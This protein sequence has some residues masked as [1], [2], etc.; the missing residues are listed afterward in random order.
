MSS[1]IKSQR[2]KRRKLNA[3]LSLI[4]N[5]CSNKICNEVIEKSP[6]LIDDLTDEI[7]S[8]PTYIQQSIANQNNPVL[9]DTS[10]EHSSC[11]ST[12]F[13]ENIRQSSFSVSSNDL[14][15]NIGNFLSISNE[16]VT[17]EN[18]TSKGASFINSW[19]LKCNVP[20]ITLNKLLKLMK[21]HEIINTKNLPLD[22]RTLLNTPKSR[23]NRIR[24]VEPGH[25]Y[26][27]GLAQQIQRF[28]PH[29]MT[30]IKVVI[31][32]DGL[33]IAMSCNNQLW[34]ILAY[35]VSSEITKTVFPVGIYYGKSKPNDS[36][37][38]LEDFIAEAK[39]LLTN[40]IDLHGHNKKVLI[41][42]FVCDAPARSYILK[43][44]GHSGYFSCTRCLYEG[45]NCESRVCFPYCKN[46]SAERT[47][48]MYVN[49]TNE[50][51]H[52][53][54]TTSKL[55]ELPGIDLIRSFPLDYMH[56]VN[57]GIVKK[58]IQLWLFKGPLNVRLPARSINLLSTALL[59]I[60]SCIPS[61]FVRKTRLVQ[62]VSRW[63]A[64]EL[65]LFILYIG[66]IVL[67]DIIS[68]DAYTNFMALH[69]AMLILL[70]PN[71]ENFL[72]YARELLEYFVKTF[73]QIYGSKHC[74]YNVHALLHICDDYEYYGPL[75][76]CS[77]FVFEN[78][79]KNLKAKIRKHEKPLEQIINRY[80]EMYDKQQP[81]SIQC[82]IPNYKLSL[83]HKC[84]PLLK[85]I[86]FKKFATNN[87]KLNVSNNSDCYILTKS[88]DVFKCF[89]FVNTYDDN[90]V[91]IGRI[92]EEK[93]TFYKKPVDTSVF[94][95]N[96]VKNLSRNFCFLDSSEI[97]CKIM[98]LNNCNSS[99]ALPVIHTKQKTNYCSL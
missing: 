61:D 48:D 83:P 97:Y 51:H 37:D 73:E 35:I 18:A 45:E 90:V 41:H 82:P 86:Q 43:I 87:I 96:I 71:H 17:H 23:N 11:N 55:T 15:E 99:I 9:L 77:A 68:S 29:N 39:E 8:S 21:E 76:E 70:S 52:V 67:K 31:G 30:E 2:S 1:I 34:P 75:D 78:Y 80:S 93:H 14:S 98:L 12:L 32:I 42:A 25:Y 40:G 69:V 6:V 38:F 62:E 47:H 16:K 57:L 50:E 44:K 53:G 84:G 5:I 63:K 91:I 60:Q 22:S 95:I 85:N 65:R 3:E 88:N 74:S 81:T 27:F 4:Q 36:N 49:M 7:P 13:N 24:I 94:N 59:A 89:N 20:Q 28:A 66:P 26:H 56:L 58:L 19:A 54:K 46:K 64:T 92:F 10:A 72:N 33:P 79:M